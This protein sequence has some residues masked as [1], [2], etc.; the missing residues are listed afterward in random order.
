MTSERVSRPGFGRVGWGAWLG[1]SGS[2]GCVGECEMLDNAKGEV[3]G[4]RSGWEVGHDN[5]RGCEDRE[6]VCL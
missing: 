6:C 2:R 1:L 3:L 5:L 4:Q